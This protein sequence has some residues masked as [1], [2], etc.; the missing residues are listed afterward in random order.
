VLRLCSIAI[1]IVLACFFVADYLIIQLIVDYYASLNHW[2]HGSGGS[3]M[4][5]RKL[6]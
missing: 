5:P 6:I 2:K 1:I 4:P 3:M